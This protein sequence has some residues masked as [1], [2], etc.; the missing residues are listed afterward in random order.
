MNRA[1]SQSQTCKRVGN[2]TFS[3]TLKEEI[4]LSLERN[5]HVLR[6]GNCLFVIPRLLSRPAADLAATE[7]LHQLDIVPHDINTRGSVYNV[8][9]GMG[10]EKTD[11]LMQCLPE[12]APPQQELFRVPAM[13][14][15][16]F[17]SCGF[18]SFQ[19]GANGLP[20]SSCPAPTQA[21]HL[22][23]PSLLIAERLSLR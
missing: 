18:S 2:I 16:P 9:R 15:S 20:V 10:F 12:D 8:L 6:A 1:T 5:T 11:D 3:W 14:E 19:W 17:R 22:P 13:L 4:M 21:P 23:P 7:I